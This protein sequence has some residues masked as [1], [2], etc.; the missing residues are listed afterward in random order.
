MILFLKGLFHLSTIESIWMRRF[1]LQKDPSRV[2]L[3]HRTLTE[4][5]LPSMMKRTLQKFVFLFINVAISITIT[6]DLWMDKG[7]LNTF[8]F[9]INFLSLDWEPK[10]VTIGFLRQKG[11]LGL[12]SLVNCKLCLKSTNLLTK[13]LCEIWRH[14]PIYNDQCS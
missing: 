12:V 5:I 14:K 3:S 11:F 13:L 10:H 9:I 8:T 6:F 4:E 1:G 7:A 2:F